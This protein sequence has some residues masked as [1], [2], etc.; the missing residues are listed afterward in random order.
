M[1]SV[2][3]AHHL[4]EGRICNEEKHVRDLTVETAAIALQLQQMLLEYSYELDVN[5][6]KDVTAYFTKEGEFVLGPYTYKGH[7]AIRKFYDERDARVLDTH[8]DGVRTAR[9]TFTNLRFA[10][11]DNT[12]ATLYFVSIYYVGEGN[13]PVPNLT[14]PATVSDGM[15]LCEREADGKWRIAK[16]TITPVFLGDN[17]FATKL[18]TKK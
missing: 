11:E 16:I 10:I 9:H 18:M 8:K 4:A 5:K 12:R 17:S 15:M 3:D 7:A 6:G 1:P 13:P 2:H 14:G